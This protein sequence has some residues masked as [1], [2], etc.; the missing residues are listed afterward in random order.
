MRLK[1]PYSQKVL[2]PG[3]ALYFDGVDDWAETS[4]YL[5][6]YGQTFEVRAIAKP[7]NNGC[8]FNGRWG[9]T[10]GKFNLYPDGFRIGTFVQRGLAPIDGRWHTYRLFHDPGTTLVVGL[11]RRGRGLL[12]PMWSAP[13]TSPS[14]VP[15]GETVAL[16]CQSFTAHLRLRRLRGL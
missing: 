1:V 13:T 12:R 14:T 16:L 10:E 3:Q 8:I 9:W 15:R 7:N 4:T 5:D 2:T 11:L 6:T